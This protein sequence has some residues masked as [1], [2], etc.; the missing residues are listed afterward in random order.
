[1]LSSLSHSRHLLSRPP[2]L[3]LV[4]LLLLLPTLQT[5]QAGGGSGGI[6]RRR[7]LF[8]GNIVSGG[9]GGGDHDD[10]AS[11]DSKS[12][13]G[14]DNSG[15]LGAKTA[16]VDDLGTLASTRARRASEAFAFAAD[17]RRRRS[18][19]PSPFA[20]DVRH[21]RS[22]KQTDGDGGGRLQ[23]SFVNTLFR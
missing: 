18:P 6:V 5:Y 14:L 11:L 23:L 19:P 12:S 2:L 8:L 22:L 15:V 7:P 1:M 10:G 17:V 9:G 4:L 21:Q 13:A 3:H 20:A 16:V